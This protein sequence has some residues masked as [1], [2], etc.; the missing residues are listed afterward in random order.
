MFAA[1][2]CGLVLDRLGSRFA[3]SIGITLIALSAPARSVSHDF[4]TS[5]S[6]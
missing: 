5:S 4:T 3:L 1:I 2:P 6:R